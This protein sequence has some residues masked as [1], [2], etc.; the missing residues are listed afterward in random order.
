MNKIIRK[1]TEFAGKKLILETGE[2][3]LRSNMAVKATF[4]D[5]VLLVTV[6]SG[7]PSIEA[8]FLGLRV[9]YEEKLYASGSIKS[10]RFVKREGKATDDAVIARRTIDHAIRPLFPKDYMDEVQVVV[11]V[12][13]LDETADPE[14]LSMIATV[15][16]LQASDVPFYG[17]VA[18][19]RIGL[20]D[21]NLVLCPSL[22]DL[23]EK[24]DL[25][26]MVSFVG[27]DQRFLAA[28]VEA[29][30][31]PEEKILEA[32]NFARD[33]LKPL[34]K[35]INDFVKEVNPEGKKYIYESKALPDETLSDITALVGEKVE[36]I[37]KSKEKNNGKQDMGDELWEIREEM[38]KKFEGTYKKVDMELAFESIKKDVVRK[39]VL[40][41]GK[42]IDGRKPTEVRPI[43]INVGVLP[44][45][46]GSALFT[47]GETQAL[48]V[49]T[50]GSP[51]DELLIQDMY[52]E[53]K[54]R[55][56]HYYNFPPYS[57]GEV[58]RFGAPNP[59]EIGH[60]MIAEKAL[61]PVIPDQAVFPYTI[62]LVSEVISSN[63][64][65][66]MA[67]TCGS[68]LSLMD[69]GVPIKD[70][71]S[72]VAMGLVVEDETFNK[73]QIL[74]DLAGEEDAG[75]FMDFK[76]TGTEEG[77]T[78]IQ[79]D[80]KLKGIP[81]EILPKIMEQSKEGRMF[82]L[83]EMQKVISKPKEEVSIYAPKMVT[84]QVNPDKIGVII[85]TGGRVIRE[86][87]EKTQSE[88]SI[89]EDGK[90]TIS[91][92]D[93]DKAEEALK[94]VEGLVKEVEVGEI[95]EGVVKELL[96]FG[97]LIEVLPG[98][99][100]LLHVSEITNSFVEN[101]NDWFKVGDKVKVKVIST[102][103]DGKFSLSKRAADDPDYVPSER[104]PRRNN[105]GRDK[106]P[107]N[108][109]GRR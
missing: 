62:M 4:G 8:D 34:V 1:E 41:E 101:V 47:R 60:G 103:E 80:I 46:H 108:R 73:Y 44:R 48:T 77:V 58:G 102:G 83:K 64:S 23:D 98:K 45:T 93:K 54:K 92:P 36:E 49:C 29:N 3:A 81:M 25:K 97:A 37:M 13:S 91:A 12:L 68:T 90:V 19:A 22:K 33:E 88:I 100:G 61:R 26:M 40:D 2:L 75:G 76:M 5:T 57:V 107:F 15:A 42:R 99:I 72:G 27:E 20:I 35:F 94:I 14:F 71:V 85:G 21:G 96:D 7:E 17:P 79:C 59:R 69:A 11:T 86:I 55:F 10:S 38:F 32:M 9:Q 70:M 39:I 87:Q 50:L 78:A 105:N 109:N 56:I 51:S 84:T 28:E 95:Y 65:S 6:V 67:S 43:S 104:N 66:S 30:I 18:T 63:G 24:S 74:T 52:G 53:R 16:C 82:I 31:L 89:E 106:R